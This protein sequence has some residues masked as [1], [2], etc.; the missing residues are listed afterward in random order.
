MK[1]LDIKM[2]SDA[3]FHRK[4]IHRGSAPLMIYISCMFSVLSFTGSKSKYLDKN[5]ST[6]LVLGQRD[7]EGFSY[8]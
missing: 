6:I 5:I 4:K 3:C 1:K 7:E 2:T 8:I